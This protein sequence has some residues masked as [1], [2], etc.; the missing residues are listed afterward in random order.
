MFDS[1]KA[2]KPFDHDVLT[3]KIIKWIIKNDIPFSMVDNNDFEDILNYLKTEAGVK[4]RKTIMNRMKELYHITKA[5]LCQL[6]GT[7]KS[8]ISITCDLWTSKNALSF[9]GI[10]GHWIDNDFVLQERLLSFKFVKGEH[11]GKNLADELIAILK[12]LGIIEKLLCITGDN[13][14]NCKTA[15][16]SR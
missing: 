15:F 12:D 16:N 13:A 14:S 5:E 6:L 11:D 4:S 1:F 7:T 8:K 3:G 10:T 9:F 2:Q